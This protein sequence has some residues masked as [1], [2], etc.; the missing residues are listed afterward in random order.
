MLPNELRPIAVPASAVPRATPTSPSG[1][2]A[3]MPVG[4]TI[5]GRAISCPRTEVARS[6]P[7]GRSAMCGGVNLSSLKAA[8]LSWSVTPFSVPAISAI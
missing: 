7:A 1:C 5:T 2:T 6:R 8:I 4:D 3:C